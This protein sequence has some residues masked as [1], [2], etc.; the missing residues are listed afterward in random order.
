MK[1]RHCG[2]ELRH[3][4]A[5]LATAPPSNAYLSQADLSKPE[6]Y[7]P[8]RVLV[9]DCCWLVQTE[10]Y[11]NAKELFTSDYAYFS[12]TSRSWLDHSRAFVNDVA[13]RFELGPKSR[14]VEVAANDGY[15]LQFIR[16]RGIPCYGI[17]PTHSTAVAARAKGIE[18][19]EQFSEGLA[20]IS[21]NRNS[22]PISRSRTTS[23][24]MSR[25]LM[26]S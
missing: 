11:A 14:V 18:I 26:T 1:C 17:E 2:N 13:A 10:D 15:L 9:C 12:S 20:R 3:V 25:T 7:Y 6:K 16:E 24:R 21:G 23:S 4:F 8:L 22:K 5:D 19:V